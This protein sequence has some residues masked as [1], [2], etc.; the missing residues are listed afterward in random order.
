[1]LA[2]LKNGSEAST[3]TEPPGLL[4]QS[5]GID[6]LCSRAG[7]VSPAALRNKVSMKGLQ[8]LAQLPRI[9]IPRT[10]VNKGKKRREKAED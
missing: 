9:P 2:T 4:W 10:S 5:G 6:V 3:F 1:V 8:D 7:L